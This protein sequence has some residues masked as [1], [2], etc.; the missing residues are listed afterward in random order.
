MNG[1][2]C[3]IKLIDADGKESIKSTFYFA[4]F[5]KCKK[6]AELAKEYTQ[7]EMEIPGIA[8]RLELA[9]KALGAATEET[10]EKANLHF[11]SV[12]EVLHANGE[13]QGELFYE[14]VCTGLQEAGYSK[15]DVEKYLPHI[16]PERF[17]DLVAKSRIGAGRLDF[18]WEGIQP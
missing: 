1:I 8:K 7:L 16:E 6:L 3:N 14:F 12:Q 11:I 5:R 15:E 10:F 18:F 2:P 9:T 17:G 13:K 4:T